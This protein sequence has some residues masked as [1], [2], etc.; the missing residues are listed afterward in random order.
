MAAAKYEAKPKRIYRSE[1]D[2]IIAGVC[3]GLGEYLGIDSVVIRIT[4]VLIT[5]FGGSGV[6]LYLIA[7][8]VMPTKFDLENNKDYV[9][10]NVQ[11]LKTKAREITTNSNSRFILGIILLVV[12]VGFL[13][14]NFNI[15]RF[16]SL[17]RFWPVILIVIGFVI[18]A[19]KE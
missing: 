13:L 7:W 18:L 9:K 4:F 8:I 1:R 10:E 2:K 17:E 16:F 12:G 6:L 5:L 3:G 11:E 15:L 19:N 14:G